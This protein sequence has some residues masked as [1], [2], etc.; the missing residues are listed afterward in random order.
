MN[1]VA[2]VGKPRPRIARAK[3]LDH[4]AGYSIFNEASI[5]DYQ[6]RSPQW[7]MGKT[8]DGTGAF[9]PEFVTADELPK[10]AAG[11]G[12]VTRLNGEVVQDA[13]T[14]DMIF[15]VETLIVILS[16]AITLSPG[17]LIVTGTPAGVA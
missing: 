16:E 13:L 4:V 17:D 5:R 2:V 6:F 3:A 11:C 14:D 9:G 7:T 10:A 15:D 1:C 8:F 12:S